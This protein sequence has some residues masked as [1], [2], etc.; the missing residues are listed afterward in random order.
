MNIKEKKSYCLL[1][2]GATVSITNGLSHARHIKTTVTGTIASL[3]G[4]NGS[5]I[6]IVFDNGRKAYF[7]W[8]SKLE[9]A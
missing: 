2:V 8:S 3:K 1:Q 6:E 5:M 7:N 9:V 4:L